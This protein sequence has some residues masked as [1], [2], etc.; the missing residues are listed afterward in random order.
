M[1]INKINYEQ[2]AMDYLEGNLNGQQLRDMEQFLERH[3]DIKKE[4]EEM[5]LFYLEADE[6]I[7][8]DQKES[9]IKE[10]EPEAIIVSGYRKWWL[11]SSIAVF[12]IFAITLFMLNMD[13]DKVHSSDETMVEQKTI[14]SEKQQP[15]VTI[16]NNEAI[17]NNDEINT[18]EEGSNREIIIEKNQE[19]VVEIKEDV[20]NDN[21][22]PNSN[23]IQKEQ[24]VARQAPQ[25][26]PTEIN[27]QTPTPEQSKKNEEP[28]I[29]AGTDTSS[30]TTES[31]N[32]A[33]PKVKH[34]TESTPIASV[35]LE[36]IFSETSITKPMEDMQLEV[37]EQFEIVKVKETRLQKLGLF[38]E[39]KRI[40]NRSTLKS[41][42]IP[43]S[44]ASK[45]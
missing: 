30:R 2:F 42:L 7:V 16:D 26:V 13:V 19:K 10:T 43:E 34:K 41:V 37:D 25:S 9:L 20:N 44:F 3:P 31:E 23:P 15:S 39:G 35:E 28:V 6:D 21:F 12:L 5:E 4:L 40:I 36:P 24:P 32:N 8:F 33:N 1:S 22:I 17:T 14:T 29:F 18:P 27:P 45:D 11:M 38:P